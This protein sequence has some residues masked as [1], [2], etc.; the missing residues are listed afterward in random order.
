MM[1]WKIKRE[2]GRYPASLFSSNKAMIRFEVLR[3]AEH[4]LF[5]LRKEPLE[6]YQRERGEQFHLPRRK[7]RKPKI[8]N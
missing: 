6:G 8:T 7:V 2:D 3:Y 5:L 4:D 1:A